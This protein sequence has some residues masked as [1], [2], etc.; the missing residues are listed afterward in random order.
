MDF[1]IGRFPMLPHC[2][3]RT[4]G[5]RNEMHQPE[6]AR[7]RFREGEMAIRIGFDSV[8]VEIKGEARGLVLD[9]LELEE[10]SRSWLVRREH[11][12]FEPAPGLET[13][14]RIDSEGTPSHIRVAVWRGNNPPADRFVRRQPKAPVRVTGQKRATA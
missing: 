12:A 4:S 8:C 1:D 7:W 14:R 10:A 6:A 3:L 13:N 2:G 11:G 5:M 9:K